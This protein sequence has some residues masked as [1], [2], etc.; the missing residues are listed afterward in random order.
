[1]QTDKET[2]DEK[3][4][5]SPGL[6]DQAKNIKRLLWLLYGTCLSLFALDFVIHRHHAHDWESL[7]GFYPLYGFAGCVILVFVAKGMRIFLMRSEDYYDDPPPT[8]RNDL[9]LF[10]ESSKPQQ[11]STLKSG[12]HDVDA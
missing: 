12:D 8:D 7:W 5:L 2:E 3:V 11:T 10:K 1:M 4:D 9:S 6:F